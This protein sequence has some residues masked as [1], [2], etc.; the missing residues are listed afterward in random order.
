M[1]KSEDTAVKCMIC[2]GKPLFS[3]DKEYAPSLIVRH[4]QSAEWLICWCE[5]AGE[6]VL[7]DGMERGDLFCRL[8]V[9][10]GHHRIHYILFLLSTA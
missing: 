7:C 8:C 9:F 4:L 10:V 5:R 1:D 3:L 2:P 6:G